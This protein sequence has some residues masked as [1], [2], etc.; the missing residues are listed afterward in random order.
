MKVLLDENMPE[1]L[2]LA[3]RRFGHQVD[4]INGLGLKGIDDVTMY[5]EVIKD[6]DLCFTRDVGFAHN[7]RQVREEINGKLLRVVLPQQRSE[8]FVPL[9]LEAFE[10]SDWSG[11]SNG[12]DWP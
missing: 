9:F 8:Q 12:S 3:L 7:V 4:S 2:L 11:Y 5:R 6:Y 1:S 10:R